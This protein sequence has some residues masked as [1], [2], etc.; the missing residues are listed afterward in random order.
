MKNLI[1][2][3]AVTL[4]LLTSACSNKRYEIKEGRIPLE[5]AHKQLF[6]GLI[7]H[8]AIKD[9]DDISISF[10][11]SP[12][13]EGETGKIRE[14]ITVT[15]NGDFLVNGEIANLDTEGDRLIADAIRRGMNRMFI[16]Q[17]SASY[18]KAQES[19]KKVVTE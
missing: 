7:H 6:T 9:T 13:K 19:K 14:K 15:A 8:G 4:L 3:T 1:T 18:K 17:A 10:S 16:E 11:S 12:T 5:I 2:F